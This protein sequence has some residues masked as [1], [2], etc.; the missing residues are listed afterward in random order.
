MQA[1][2]LVYDIAS[3]APGQ[4]PIFPN[5][6]PI[7]RRR[8]V[9]IN[10]S[11]WVVPVGAEPW[12]MLHAMTEVGVT[13]HLTKFAAEEGANLVALAQSALLKEVA[14]AEKRAADSLGRMETIHAI[15]DKPERN[16][17]FLRSAKSVLKRT[18]KLLSDLCQAA[19]AFGID[20]ATLPTTSCLDAVNRLKASAEAR[21]LC[22]ANLT[23]QTKDDGLRTAAEQDLVPA[24][25]LADNCEDNGGDAGEVRTLF[26]ENA[27]EWVPDNNE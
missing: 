4:P 17:T 5:P 1:S 2:L 16:D 9:R 3:P 10:L 12:N 23:E 19:G 24:G 27:G 26:D 8:A 22:Y 18:E 6:S 20:T 14:E 21:A 7:L 15:S 11:V 25:I 13:W